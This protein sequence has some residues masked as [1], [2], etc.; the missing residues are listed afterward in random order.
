MIQT[1]VLFALPKSIFLQNLKRS[2]PLT[3]GSKPFK[4][5]DVYP[6]ELQDELDP[7]NRQ[8]FEMMIYNIVLDMPVVNQVMP[9]NENFKKI[10]LIRDPLEYIIYQL[11][12][13]GAL[14][15]S[16]NKAAIFCPDVKKPITKVN[17]KNLTFDD[18]ICI[19]PTLFKMPNIYHDPFGLQGRL[20]FCKFLKI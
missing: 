13:K 14:Y 18:W 6:L 15:D 3:F 20:D 5:P 19:L 9:K 16:I 1:P 4:L 11:V 8:R 10:T 12:N 17:F 2:T 7:E